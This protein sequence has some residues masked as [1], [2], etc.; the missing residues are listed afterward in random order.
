MALPSEGTPA[1]RDPAEAAMQMVRGSGTNEETEAGGEGPIP[2]DCM[3]IPVMNLA[4]HGEGFK[5]SVFIARK[6]QDDKEG[7]MMYNR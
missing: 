3:E 6:P 5:I 4:G 1:G 7:Q 2:K